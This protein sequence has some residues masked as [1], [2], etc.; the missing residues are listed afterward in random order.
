MLLSLYYKYYPPISYS[1]YD[2][3]GLDSSVRVGRTVAVE[4]LLVAYDS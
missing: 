4:S 3:G 1:I 2:M